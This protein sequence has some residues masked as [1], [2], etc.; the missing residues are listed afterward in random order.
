LFAEEKFKAPPMSLEAA[1]AE[2]TR[3]YRPGRMAE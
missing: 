1:L 3:D 2:A